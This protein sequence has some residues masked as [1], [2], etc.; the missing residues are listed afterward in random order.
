M[1]HS[2]QIIHI[3]AGFRFWEKAPG[4]WPWSAFQLKNNLADLATLLRSVLRHNPCGYRPNSMLALSVS[5]HGV[6]LI[7]VRFRLLLSAKKRLTS[8]R[9]CSRFTYVQALQDEKHVTTV[10][11]QLGAVA[12]LNGQGIRCRRVHTQNGLDYRSNL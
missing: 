7:Y 6:P 8:N 12:C 1:L 3:A 11:C 5:A 2:A 10:T 4:S 9:R